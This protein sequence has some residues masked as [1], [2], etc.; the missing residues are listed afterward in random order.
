LA[1]GEIGHSRKLH[2]RSLLALVH[3]A[4]PVGALKADAMRA[5][6][7]AERTCELAVT[8]LESAGYLSRVRAREGDRRRMLISLTAAGRKAVDDPVVAEALLGLPK[9]QR[10]HR[11]WM[12]DPLNP[13]RVEA[14][15]D[16]WRRAMRA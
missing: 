1:V 4:H 8:D 2:L 7:I 15:L 11:E 5:F 16:E 9:R 3:G 14:K 10:E 6:D 13:G 12:R